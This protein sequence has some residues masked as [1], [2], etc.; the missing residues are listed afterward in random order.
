MLRWKYITLF[1]DRHTSSVPQIALSRNADVFESWF[2][3]YLEGLNSGK[4]GKVGN[5]VCNICQKE[6]RISMKFLSENSTIQDQELILRRQQ[7]TK[8]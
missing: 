3:T 1:Q 6:L 5:Y 7:N 2:R 4:F 8:N